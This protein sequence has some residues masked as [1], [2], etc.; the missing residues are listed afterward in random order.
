MFYIFAHTW[1]QCKRHLQPAPPHTVKYITKLLEIYFVTV[2]TDTFVRGRWVADLFP[3]GGQL[4]FTLCW[5]QKNINTKWHIAI[6]VLL[7]PTEKFWGFPQTKG[8]KN[9][10][11]IVCVCVICTIN[12][13]CG[14]RGEVAQSWGLFEVSDCPASNTVNGVNE[15]VCMYF[16]WTELCP[17][18]SCAS[19]LL[20]LDQVM[21]L[22][23][24]LGTSIVSSFTSTMSKELTYNSFLSSTCEKQHTDSGNHIPIT[25][26]VDTR[27]PSWTWHISLTWSLR[28]PMVRMFSGSDTPS[29]MVRSPKESPSSSTLGRPCSSVR[30]AACDRAP[31]RL[32][33]VWISWPLKARRTPFFIK[34]KHSF[35]AWLKLRSKIRLIL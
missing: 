26:C 4:V 24:P 2:R 10:Y 7:F 12:H 17:L 32:L 16:V 20:S 9:V 1:A 27:N 34:K 5:S 8:K 29:A 31:S 14:H 33:K 25:D 19:Y 28:K 30:R 35:T 18:P 21:Y 6:L 11:S 15:F 22:R 3:E 23:I 13:S